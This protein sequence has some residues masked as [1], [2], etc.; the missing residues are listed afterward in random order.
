MSKSRKKKQETNQAGGY[1]D[2]SIC[3]IGMLLSVVM[4]ACLASGIFNSSGEEQH[5]DV[6]LFFIALG[7]GVGMLLVRLRCLEGWTQPGWAR[8]EIAC[9]GACGIVMAG[10]CYWCGMRQ[11]GGFDCSV[12][13]DTA[14]RL[15]NGQKPYVDFPC[16][17]PVGFYLGAELAFRLFGVFWSS[18]VKV[19]VLYLLLT[20]FW[21]YAVLR[22]VFQNRYLVLVLVITCESMS[23]IL[24]SF[25]WYNP[26][27]NTAVVLYVAC[28]AA[29]LARPASRW[30]W[31]SVCMSLFLTAM[32]KPNV[33]GV[34]ILGG[35]A[36]LLI[37]PRTLWR[38]CAVT[39]IAFI[40]WL[41]VIA[42][43]GASIGQVLGGYF[44]V[45]TFAFSSNRF[46]VDLKP[47]ERNLAWASLF[48][49]IPGLVH[50]AWPGSGLRGRPA[51]LVLASS[52]FVASMFG[53]YVNGDPKLVDLSVGLLAA[54]FL[55]GNIRQD[56]D[57][58]RVSPNWAAY[59]V[60]VCSTFT[61]TCLGEAAI[62][63]RM[64]GVDAFFEYQMEDGPVKEGFFKGMHSGH[65]LRAAMDAITALRARGE[66][67]NIYFGPRLQWAYAAFGIPSPKGLPIW[68]HPGGAFPIKDDA[69]YET[70]WIEHRYDPVLI[71]DL[72]YIGANMFNTIVHS[73]GIE[74]CIPLNSA[75]IDRTLLILRRK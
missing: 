2:R 50:A 24:D 55:M 75:G 10:F 37:N 49:L 72:P 19:N 18:L 53:F 51:L 27:T 28:V 59:L 71:M 14:W 33:A 31:L 7:F 63:H 48:A 34:A 40:L 30:L 46:L 43:H 13:I 15:Y 23:M 9:V 5:V 62:R 66:T 11:F 12:V 6:I 74:Q 70:R 41:G 32:M 73:Y 45:G 22:Q 3:Y 38:A 58:L 64:R 61:F 8:S 25:W 44:S 36:A 16:T 39:L 69:M 29:V 42:I 56:E 57:T 54:T 35:T 52:A 60:L 4:M 26:V 1:W 65:N 67:S 20:F 17:V 47:Y 21:T 68:W